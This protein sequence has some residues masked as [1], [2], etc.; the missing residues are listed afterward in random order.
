MKV[1]QGR[2]EQGIEVGN[3][4][5]KYA[6][7]NPVARY[8][9]QG[10]T[11][12]LDELVS[13]SGQRI[14]H[15]IGCGEGVLSLRWMAQGMAVRSCDFSEIAIE[16]A[17]ENARTHGH[18]PMLFTQKNI[19]DLS[20]EDRAPLVVCCEVLEHLESP[21][22]AL[23]KLAAVA[24]PWLI[25]SVPREPVWSVMNMARG[26]YWQDWGNTPGHIQRWSQRSFIQM[27]SAQMEIVAVRSPLPW[28]MLLCRTPAQD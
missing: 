3:H 5:D 23:K 15:E 1:A 26:K 27:V 19:Y 28:T 14:I 16:L 22:L 20:A 21:E 18:N 7:K 17:R 9:M 2:Q 6:S 25:V 11:K 4:Y 12:A 8:L 24:A 10:F 13:L